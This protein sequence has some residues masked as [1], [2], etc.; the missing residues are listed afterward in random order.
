MMWG[1]GC[2]EEEGGGGGSKKTTEVQSWHWLRAAIK[3]N[4]ASAAIIALLSLID[5][6]EV[7][8]FRAYHTTAGGHKW[9]DFANIHH[10]WA[11]LLFTFD[12]ADARPRLQPVVRRAS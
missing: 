4:R 8:L 10:D 5:V 9:F 2:G 3:A 6:L 7:P 12:T 1:G 11:F